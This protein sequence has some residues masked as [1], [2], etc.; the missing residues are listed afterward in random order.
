[1]NSTKLYVFLLNSSNYSC[2]CDIL[3]QNKLKLICILTHGWILLSKWQFRWKGIIP[4]NKTCNVFLFDYPNSSLYSDMCAKFFLV[5]IV[6]NNDITRTKVEMVQTWRYLFKLWHRNNEYT[7]CIILRNFSFEP[8]CA[9][10]N[11]TGNWPKPNNDFCFF[12]NPDRNN[13]RCVNC[14][15]NLDST[16]LTARRGIYWITKISL[17]K[18]SEYKFTFSAK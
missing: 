3:K 2:W 11:F 17:Y 16:I 6:A 14:T 1:M 13:R 4:W 10:L 7:Q 18:W 5:L 8:F 12:L 15:L 9:R